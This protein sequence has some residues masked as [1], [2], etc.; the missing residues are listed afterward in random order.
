M[1]NETE[2]NLLDYEPYQEF[3]NSLYREISN[4]SL[5]LVEGDYCSGRTTFIKKLINQ[6]F[7][8]IYYNCVD[9]KGTKIVKQLSKSVAKY[10]IMSMFNDK[11]QRCKNVILV[12]DIDILNYYDKGGLTAVN[13][14]IKTSNKTQNPIIFITSPILEDKRLFELSTLCNKLTFPSLDDDIITKIILSYSNKKNKYTINFD[15]LLSSIGGNITILNKWIHT[16]FKTINQH[17]TT[18]MYKQTTRELCSTLLNSPP[19]LYQHEEVIHSKERVTLSMVLH[20]NL[21]GSLEQHIKHMKLLCD[22]DTIDYIIFKI[23]NWNFQVYSSLLKNMNTLYIFR[24]NKPTSNIIFTKIL[25]KYATQYNNMLYIHN[26]Q[27]KYFLLREDLL[28]EDILNT[29]IEDTRERKRVIK[30]LH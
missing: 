30:I 16:N 22:A 26:I 7:R 12:D 2:I 6:Q 8:L 25:T 3:K 18:E 5:I 19:Q 1:T 28:N 13:K 27:Q 4:N 17:H 20:E 29:Y 10:D 23:Q 15:A 24:E 9:V 14:F 21:R 11:S